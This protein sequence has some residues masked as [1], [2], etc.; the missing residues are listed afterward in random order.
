[1]FLKVFKVIIIIIILICGGVE[2]GS[3]YVSLEHMAGWNSLCGP[4]YLKLTEIC[5]LLLPEY[6]HKRHLPTLAVN[7]CLLN[8][9][10]M[11][12]NQAGDVV[13]LIECLHN[14]CINL[15]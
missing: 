2:K 6:R 10:K 14:M 11:R 13:K 4:D 1:M 5:L 12:R 8:D 7:A 9:G 15:G 3:H